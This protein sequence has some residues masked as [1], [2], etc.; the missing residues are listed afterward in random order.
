MGCKPVT[1]EATEAAREVDGPDG[2]GWLVFKKPMEGGVGACA[3]PVQF[4][5]RPMGQLAAA[6]TY[7]ENPTRLTNLKWRFTQM[8]KSSLVEP[9][10]YSTAQHCIRRTPLGRSPVQMVL[11]RLG[12]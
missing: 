10:Q 9:S 5:T 7:L 8:E 1:R 11:P 2:G 12:A 3:V 4:P 6:R